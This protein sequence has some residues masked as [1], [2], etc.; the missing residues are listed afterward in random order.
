MTDQ[1]WY[2]ECQTNYEKV[3]SDLVADGYIRSKR[4]DIYKEQFAR[5]GQVLVITRSLGSSNWWA[6]EIENG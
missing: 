2:D 4:S 1:K 6:K 3:A 5:D